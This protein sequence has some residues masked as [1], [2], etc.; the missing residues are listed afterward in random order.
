MGHVILAIRGWCIMGKVGE[1]QP[2]HHKAVFI[3]RV[4]IEGIILFHVGNADN[5][6]VLLQYHAGAEMQGKIAGRDSDLLPVGLFQIQ[7]SAKVKLFG[8]VGESGTH[9]HSPLRFLCSLSRFGAG[10]T[11][12]RSCGEETGMV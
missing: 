8:A 3:D 5:G 11:P 6:V 1:I 2:R 10:H 12:R 7:C 4:V 9:E